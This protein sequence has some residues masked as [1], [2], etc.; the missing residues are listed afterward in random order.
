[1]CK[2]KEGRPTERRGE[3]GKGNTEEIMEE[4]SK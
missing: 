2:K 4:R 1:V 3:K